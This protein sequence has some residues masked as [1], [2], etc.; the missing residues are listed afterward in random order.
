M[1]PNTALTLTVLLILL[2][3]IGLGLVVS[4]VSQPDSQMITITLDPQ[5][6]PEY[7]L[8][9]VTFNDIP[10]DILR[11]RFPDAWA[12]MMEVKEGAPAMIYDMRQQIYEE[13]HG[14]RYVPE[15]GSYYDGRY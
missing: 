2:A 15:E 5:T 14:E 9:L 13:R 1:K 3:G 10:L 4:I 12:A 11:T 8:D 6:L 7:D